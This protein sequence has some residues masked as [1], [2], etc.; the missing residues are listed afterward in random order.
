MFTGQLQVQLLQYIAVSAL[1][2]PGRQAGGSS[3]MRL[4]T[5]MVTDTAMQMISVGRQSLKYISSMTALRTISCTCSE[6]Q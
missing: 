4:A 1:L 3:V 6:I 2:T 5:L